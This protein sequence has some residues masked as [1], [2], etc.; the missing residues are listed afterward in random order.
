MDLL[1][2]SFLMWAQQGVKSIRGNNYATLRTVPSGGARHPFELYPL[3]ISVEGLEPGLYHYL[4]LTH[5]LELLQA[6]DLAEPDVR[7]KISR[8]LCGQP[9]ALKGN[10]IFYYSLVPYRGEWRY[11]FDAHRPMMIDA[12]HVTENLYLACA[13]LGLGTCAIAAV[14]TD[15]ASDLFS[16]DGKEEYIFYSAPVGTISDADEEEEQAF[17]AFLKEDTACSISAGGVLE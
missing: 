13:A 9:W 8:S 12:G 4:P 17:Y 15:L 6:M 5:E 2:L 3:I 16:L 14:D 11:S 10:V 7:D 1:T